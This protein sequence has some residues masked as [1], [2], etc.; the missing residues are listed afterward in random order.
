MSFDDE[1]E[2]GFEDAFSGEERPRRRKY[3]DMP[4]ELEEPNYYEGLDPMRKK[5]LAVFGGT[6][7]PIHNGHIRLAEKIL[8]LEL[9]DDVMFVPAKHQPLKAEAPHS[10]PEQRME[11]LHLALAGNEHFMFSDIE[12]QREGENSYTIDTLSILRKVYPDCKLIFLM[13][14][15]SLCQLHQWKNAFELV[16]H[17]EFI[18][19]PRPG[20]TMPSYAELVEHFGSKNAV[21][22]QKSVLPDDDLP[23]WNVSSSELRESLAAGDDA[24]FLPAGVQE[25]IKNNKIYA[26]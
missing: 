23:M 22:L 10:T 13:G 20:V 9:A 7:D 3:D 26:R 21:K 17:Y 25:Y 1:F 16:N 24:G 6:F 5:R 8:E 18:I 12:L 4:R 14:T 11:M 15:D 19:Y 2:K